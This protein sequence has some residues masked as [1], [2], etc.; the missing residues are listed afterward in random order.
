M[1]SALSARLRR[2]V[3]RIRLTRRRVV[4]GSAVLVVLAA[5][6]GWAV[7]PA[8]ASY[9]TEDRMITVRTGPADD[10][11]VTLDTTF[12][13]P[14]RASA[15]HP[16]PAVLLAHGFSGSKESV[17][18]D[19]KQ[20]ADH[21]FAVLAW[22]AEGFGRSTGQIHLDSPDWE[23]KDARRLVDWLAARPEVRQDAPGDPRVAAVGGSY[24]GAPA[25]LLAGSDRRAGALRPPITWDD[26]AG[27]V[28]PGATRA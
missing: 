18:D 22:T 5:V 3:P 25:P 9:R 16:V 10:Q 7:W 6:V 1:P 23:V 12:Y 20:L 28:L 21:G 14:K 13:V 15:A 8:P 27:A 26:P 11:D 2:A 17:A 24:G 19:A 4:A